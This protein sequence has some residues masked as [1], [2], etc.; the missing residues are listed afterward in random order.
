MNGNETIAPGR[1]ELI[2]EAVQQYGS[3]R[4]RVLGAS[5]RP[6]VRSGDALLVRRTTL[7]GLR[8]GDVAVFLR[9][10]RMFAHRVVRRDRRRGVVTKGDVLP[11]ADAPLAPGELL[12]RAVTVTRGSRHIVM[13]LPAR[14]A[15]AVIVAFLSAHNSLW[16]PAAMAAKQL[17]SSLG[18]GLQQQTPD[19]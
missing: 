17:L 19:D 3:V 14:R 9:E 8:R 2:A 12:G 11:A 18:Q 15:L 10:G 13:D 6:A 1:A 16:Y 5:M 4:I 7:E